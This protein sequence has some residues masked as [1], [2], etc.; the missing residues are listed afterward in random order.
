MFVCLFEIVVKR[1]D[2]SFIWN[3]CVAFHIHFEWCVCECGWC[4]LWLVMTSCKMISNSCRCRQEKLI[5]CRFIFCFL[6]L[7]FIFFSSFPFTN[8]ICANGF[9]QSENEKLQR[10]IANNGR[11][12]A[13]VALMLINY[14]IY[15]SARILLTTDEWTNRSFGAYSFSFSLSVCFSSIK[16]YSLLVFFFDRIL[17]SHSYWSG[18]WQKRQATRVNRLKTATNEKKIKTTIL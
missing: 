4:A 3:L 1:V 11:R 7:L 14:F 13:I 8:L 10:T 15:Y 18:E 6:R 17:F 9:F 2:A 16:F 12:S 5:S